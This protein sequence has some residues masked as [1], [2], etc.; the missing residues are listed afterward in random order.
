MIKRSIAAAS[1]A[2]LTPLIFCY[3][4]ISAIFSDSIGEKFAALLAP[5]AAELVPSIICVCLISMPLLYWNQRTRFYSAAGLAIIGSLLLSATW[6][7]HLT[8]GYLLFTS[9]TGFCCIT[10]CIVITG[11]KILEDG[12][13]LLDEAPSSAP[14]LYAFAM[15]MIWLK[16]S[17]MTT[18]SF[19]LIPL[20]MEFDENAKLMAIIL[21]ISGCYVVFLGFGLAF[22]W[23][24]VLPLAILSEC[25]V[26]YT[27]Y[28]QAA[29]TDWHNTAAAL[30]QIFPI[31]TS[32]LGAVAMILLLSPS[33]LSYYF[34]R[35]DD[36]KTGSYLGNTL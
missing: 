8:I 18:F 15:G 2:V 25:S 19:G 29:A 10:I 17:L 6:F 14:R 32:L 3:I 11:D 27:T 1:D 4:V 9:I 33:N 28:I 13:N 7:G 26:A 31:F 5:Y 20:V 34:S 16:I 23:K 35:D 36:A 24:V 22:R 30:G 12:D 21:A